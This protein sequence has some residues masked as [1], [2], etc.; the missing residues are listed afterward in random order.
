MKKE[1]LSWKERASLL[2]GVCKA[3]EYLHDRSI[4]HRDL[5][6][7]NVLLTKSLVPK[8]ID[9]GLSRVISAA[10]A[11]ITQR[12][13]TSYYMAPEVVIGD[14]TYG[15]KCDV[16]SFAM[17][18][19]E[20]AHQN[21]EPFGPITDLRFNLELKIATTAD[22]RPKFKDDVQDIPQWMKDL[23]MRSWD[24]EAEKRPS[25]EEIRLEFQEHAEEGDGSV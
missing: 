13:G 7:M 14:G 12:I 22:F 18:A 3:M 24:H 21:F 17:L 11:Q 4:I 9:F 16:F 23:I 8:L 1:H 10:A 6:A 25:F 15:N 5:K 19:F 2:L 20:V